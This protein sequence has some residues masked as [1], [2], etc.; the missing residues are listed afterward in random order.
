[1]L[2]E[3]GK[4]V[5]ERVGNLHFVGTERSDVWAGYVEGAVRS[6]VRGAREVTDS[7][8]GGWVAAKP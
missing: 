2:T 4:A 8:G 6:G 7:L 1:M 3:A 5:A